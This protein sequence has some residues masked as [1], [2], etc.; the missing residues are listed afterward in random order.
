M[1]EG[2]TNSATLSSFAAKKPSA[3]KIP[4][5]Q[6]KSSSVLAKKTA[7]KETNV[8]K[9]HS[10]EIESSE[11]SPREAENGVGRSAALNGHASAKLMVSALECHN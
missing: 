7:L 10:I 11:S 8:E 5:P 3:S 4:P 6:N 2:A 1:P 9:V